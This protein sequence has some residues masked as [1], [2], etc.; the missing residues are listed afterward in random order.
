MSW[1]SILGH[2]AI[3]EQL[4]IAYRSGRLAHGFLFCGPDGIGKELFA[5]EFAKAL[6][7]EKP[8]EALSACDTCQACVLVSA[9]THPDVYWARKPEDKMEFP[10]DTIR[11]LCGSLGLKPTRG[12][13]KVAIVVGADDFNAESANAFLKSLEE[14]P[15][16]T[17]VILIAGSVETQLPTI[18]S[19]CQIVSFAP[20]S[21]SA[22][23][24]ILRNQGVADD[25]QMERLIRL[26][27][28]SA[29]QAIALN[30]PDVWQLRKLILETLAADR[31]NSQRL[32]EQWSEFIEA[33][34]KES[35]AQRLRATIVIRIVS[36]LLSQ[37]MSLAVG[38]NADGADALESA[39]LSRI[40]GKYDVEQLME[41]LDHC[42]E[43]DRFVERRV[44]LVLL[45]DWLTQKLS[46]LKA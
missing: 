32:I 40:A 29:Q 34:G 7:C 15:P 22:L 5:K 38:R 1:A 35:A 33:A 18:R 28:G 14:P 6:L 45:T 36:D 41:L 12:S 46:P 3:R 13:R 24:Q 42:I 39:A 11:E 31:P 20:L 30:D 2:D 17:T 27:G 25:T 4:Q 16:G 43:A 8:A 26:A 37:A 21:K 10:I 23:T 44:Q 19:R 9:G